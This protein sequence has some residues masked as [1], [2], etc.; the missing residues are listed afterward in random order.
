MSRLRTAAGE[1][2]A[3]GE[4]GTLFKSNGKERQMSHVEADVSR[5]SFPPPMVKAEE[6]LKD[7]G[8]EY[9]GRWVALRDDE[10]VAVGDSFSQLHAQLE[11]LS[12]VLVTL[13][14]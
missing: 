10:L 2:F 4:A 7:H 9:V 8:E 5:K 12:D 6:W 14:T 3:T 11:S 13:V 1:P